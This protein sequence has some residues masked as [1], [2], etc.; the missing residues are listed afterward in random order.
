MGQATTRSSCGGVVGT[1]WRRSTRSDAGAEPRGG[2]LRGGAG[3]PGP[4]DE[5]VGWDNPTR[6]RNLHRLMANDRLLIPP[7]VRVANLA[8][9]A[10]GL[11]LQHVAGDWL[12][13]PGDAPPSGECAAGSPPKLLRHGRR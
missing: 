2:Q 10:L 7:G 11:A 4:R 9:H 8:S 5:H 6:G 1:C 3:A 13:Q 12:R